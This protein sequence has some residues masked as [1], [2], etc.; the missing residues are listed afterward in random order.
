M[1]SNIVFRDL[2]VPSYG[3]RRKEWVQIALAAA[4]VASSLIG[5]AASKKKQEAAERVQRGR[6]NSENA[7]YQ[8]R[9]NEKYTDTAA[10]QAMINE[11]KDYARENWKKASGAAAVTGGTDAATAQAKE[12]GNKMIQGAI[13]NMASAD[14]ARKDAADA[15]HMQM[16]DNFAKQRIAMEQSKAE[17]IANTASG[18]SN[19]LM[20]MAT[21]VGGDKT[22]DVLSKRASAT[23]SGGRDNGSISANLPALKDTTKGVGN[24]NK[25]IQANGLDNAAKKGMPQGEHG[26]FFDDLWKTSKVKNPGTIHIG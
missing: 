10:G 4:S 19:G 2:S 17:N 21:A 18:V 8:R 3:V 12:A 26:H 1:M 25:S 9:Y 14:T 5:G 23:L 6:E 24:I 11:A 7:W 13:R 20:S 15:T 22:K 16:Q